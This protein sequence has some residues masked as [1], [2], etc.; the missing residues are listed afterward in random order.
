[1]KLQILSPALQGRF[2]HTVD[3]DDLP[4]GLADRW[5]ARG[6][7]RELKKPKKKTTESKTKAKAENTSASD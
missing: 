5:L 7:A 1:M 2:G 4:K 6:Q 3:S